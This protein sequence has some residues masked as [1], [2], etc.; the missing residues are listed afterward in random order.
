MKNM[1]VCL[2]AMVG[3]LLVAA[4]A[5]AGTSL[6]PGTGI[7]VAPAS[8][9]PSIEEMPSEDELAMLFALSQTSWADLPSFLVDLGLN[10]WWW[11]NNLE[12][13][14]H[15]IPSYLPEASE[16]NV[17][18]EFVAL[19]SGEQLGCYMQ[20]GADQIVCIDEWPAVSWY[21]QL[22]SPTDVLD[23]LFPMA[24]HHIGGQSAGSS[25]QWSCFD[26]RSRSPNAAYYGL[27]G[28]FGG[29]GAAIGGLATHGAGLA[30][31]SSVGTFVAGAVAANGAGTAAA[32]IVAVFAGMSAGAAVVAGAVVVVA[33]GAGIAAYA[34]YTSGASGGGCPGCGA[35]YDP[36][37][38]DCVVRVGADIC[39][40]EPK[41]G[42]GDTPPGGGAGAEGDRE[43]DLESAFPASHEWDDTIFSEYAGCEDWESHEGSSNE[44]CEECAWYQDP[45]D[46]EPTTGGATSTSY[47]CDVCVTGAS[48][49]VGGVQCWSITTE[50]P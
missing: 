9:L 39:I 4:P 44:A 15:Q 45:A 8:Q 17:F 49:S 47:G 18:V 35:G 37:R 6:I 34:V 14:V 24:A 2:M 31:Y 27:A 29:A 42:D 3:A 23:I 20:S 13:S 38:W 32:S 26:L 12:I 19:Q 22:L 10:R 5:S 33:I 40:C 41:G 1:I 48:A 11:E 30:I 25:L 43:V 28:A 36:A 7:P 21:P 50:T 46:M 16:Y